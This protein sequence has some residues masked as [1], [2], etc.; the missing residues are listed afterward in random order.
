LAL[1]DTKEVLLFLATAGVVVPLFRRLKISPVIGFLGAG[2]LL[3]PHGL[4][5]F[6]DGSWL[7]L[8]QLENTGR[9]AQIAEF[10]VVFLLFM[11]GLELSYERL[12]RLR[13]LV[14]GLGAGQVALSAILIGEIAA[15]IFGLPR[16][17]ALVVGGALALSSTAIVIPVMA[18]RRRLSTAAGR[19]AFSVLLF[20]D[21]MVAPLLFTVS[22]AGGQGG[23]ATG[24]TSPSG[25]AQ[26]AVLRRAG[27]CA[28]RGNMCRRQSHARPNCP[29][30]I[31]A[32][33]TWGLASQCA[34]IPRRLCR[35]F[36]SDGIF[37]GRKRPMPK[38]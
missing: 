21:L 19:A 35:R 10:G 38:G 26:E 15:V 17:A 14:F 29:H 36:F 37:S 22:M 30:I 7:G 8:L 4:G 24:L 33:T 34:P 2:V 23:T 13:R 9:I 25:R 28:R 16:G 5:R 3:G 20:Q 31:P 1:E 11:I 6:P 18:E 32:P 12:A 27:S